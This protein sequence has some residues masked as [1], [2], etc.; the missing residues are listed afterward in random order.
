MRGEL[1]EL[2]PSSFCTGVLGRRFKI[3]PE[4]ALVGEHGLHCT[5][6]HVV[7]DDVEAIAV[8]R[9]VDDEQVLREERPT[10]EP[11]ERQYLQE[12]LRDFR[13]DGL[14]LLQLLS[15]V[16]V[17]HGKRL[18]VDVWCTGLDLDARLVIELHLGLEVFD[19]AV[20]GG[21]ACSGPC[22]RHKDHILSAW[23]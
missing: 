6:R 22:H 11:L 1:D 7:P 13:L 15:A 2:H 17:D 21:G 19:K 10:Q 12:V 16:R 8:R 9:N 14:E 4:E 5:A 18:R 23:L 3:L 20:A